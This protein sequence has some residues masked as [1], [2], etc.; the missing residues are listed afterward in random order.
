MDW[1]MDTFFNTQNQTIFTAILLT[2]CAIL[3]VL[4]AF[5]FLK[6]RGLI[7]IQHLKS[8]QARMKIVEVIA[9][10]TKRRLVLV[11]RDNQEHLILIGGNNDL[12]VENNI[13]VSEGESTTA[14]EQYPQES[15]KKSENLEPL[16]SNTQ[17]FEQEEIQ[18]EDE[19]NISPP[20]SLQDKLIA[21]LDDARSK[22]TND[23]SSPQNSNETNADFKK[24]IDE[25]EAF[26]N[27]EMEQPRNRFLKPAKAPNQIQK[28]E[29]NPQSKVQLEQKMAQLL[30]EI[31]TRNKTKPL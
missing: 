3:V 30:G 8:K 17:T 2:S 20:P 5:W 29:E 19:N 7:N 28:T 24:P 27:K 22:Q 11:S 31:A 6:K 9:I 26:L 15:F 10:D 14:L 21:T 1:L 13:N 4:A 18:V 16:T 12:I 23:T 25:F